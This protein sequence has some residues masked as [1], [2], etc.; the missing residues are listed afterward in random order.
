MGW[1]KDFIKCLMVCSIKSKCDMSC[2]KNCC[3]SSCQIEE[4]GSPMQTPNIAKKE[5]LSTL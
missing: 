3:R 2:G 5:I 1:F 4:T